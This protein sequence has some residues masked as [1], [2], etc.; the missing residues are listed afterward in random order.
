[1]IPE[2]KSGRIEI[3]QSMSFEIPF[4]IKTMCFRLDQSHDNYNNRFLP[5]RHLSRFIKN[6]TESF[7]V[8]S[9]RDLVNVQPNLTKM[10]IVNDQYIQIYADKPASEFR[11]SFVAYSDHY[12]DSSDEFLIKNFYPKPLVHCPTD[13]IP[14]PAVMD[15][16]VTVNLRKPKTIELYGPGVWRDKDRVGFGLE[17]PDI[18]ILSMGPKRES[19]IRVSEMDLT[20]YTVSDLNKD[21]IAEVRSLFQHHSD[22]FGPL[23]WRKI[24]FIEN[25]EGWNIVQP[26]IILYSRPSQPLFRY[27]QRRWLNWQYWS[28]STLTAAQW[29]G[30]MLRSAPVD[31]W[32]LAGLC[33]FASSLWLADQSER[34]NLINYY[35]HEISWLY[36]SYRQIQEITASLLHQEY[37]GARLTNESL[38]SDSSEGVSHPLLFIK[39]AVAFRSVLENIGPDHMKSFF[40]DILS[41]YKGKMITPRKFFDGFSEYVHR[42]KITGKP[43]ELLREW[44]VRKGWPEYSITRFIREKLP[45]GR[46]LT[47]ATVSSESDLNP[48]FRLRIR[49]KAGQSWFLNP[50]KSFRE[51][52]DRQQWTASLLTELEP[53]G[54]EIDPEHRFFDRNRF[55]N[56]SEAG[57]MDFFPFGTNT[58]SDDRY[59][60]VW[61]PYMFRRPGEQSSLAVQFAFFKYLHSGFYLKLEGSP[62]GRTAAAHFRYQ[63]F[64]EL[65]GGSLGLSVMQDYHHVRTSE[66]SAAFASY[67]D[68]WLNSL[69]PLLTLRYHQYPG[70]VELA[71]PSA[72]PGLKGELALPGPCRA[73]AEFSVELAPGLVAGNIFYQRYTALLRPECRLGGGVLYHGR[74]FRGFLK[75]KGVFRPESAAF[76]WNNL[77]EA[78]VRVDFANLPEVSSVRSLNHELSFPVAASEALNFFHLSQKVRARLFYDSGFEN[79]RWSPDYESSGFGL[80]LPLGGEVSGMGTLTLSRLSLTTILYSRV[81]PEIYRKPRLLFDVSGE[82]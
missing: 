16:P 68:A 78:G 25:Q 45:G 63:A 37:P 34:R 48:P 79:G 75:D 54:A 12:M 33:D 67:H 60:S 39:Q 7:A 41:K 47:Q 61:V 51:G 35:D 14:Y 15:V 9:F 80:V 30:V 71:H 1:M 64:S 49:D 65:I 17:D 32:L 4:P 73:D 18:T 13:E 42:N 69:T 3:W 8:F 11:L 38:K 74:W 19:R 20:F 59:T 26:G 82:F 76:R 27:L 21:F 77:E 5:L 10:N 52:D 6:K 22:L 36:F 55:N 53:A 23:P 28:L 62:G 81:G 2:T 50:K 46:W 66:I 72:L 24:I 44:W 57:G 70:H 31:D 56:S 40:R 43:E 29:A 58:L